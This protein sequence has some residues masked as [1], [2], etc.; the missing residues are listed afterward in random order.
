MIVYGGGICDGNA[1]NH[2]N[3]PIVLAGRGGGTIQPGRHLVLPGEVP[4]GNLYLSMLD[5]LGVPAE[6]IGDSTGRLEAIAHA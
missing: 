6:H 1:H 5:R 4:M 2:D 3:L